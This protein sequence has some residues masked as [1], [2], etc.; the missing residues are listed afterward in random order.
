[1]GKKSGSGSGI[2][3]EQPRSYFPELR[4]HF[5]GLKYLNSL[6]RIRDRK[7]SNPGSGMEKSRIRDRE[8]HPGSATL[9]LRLLFLFVQYSSSV[10][11][12]LFFASSLLPCVTK[13]YTLITCLIVSLLY[14]S[15]PTFCQSSFLVSLSVSPSLCFFFFTVG[16]HVQKCIHWHSA[17]RRKW[18]LIC[19]YS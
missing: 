19:S 14:I 18:S 16:W 8:K 7:D 6:M 11:I 4:N 9:P 2:R 3:D 13:F 17:L 12:Y 15:F 10:L 5:F 1:M